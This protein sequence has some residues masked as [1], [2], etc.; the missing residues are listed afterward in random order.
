[1]KNKNILSFKQHFQQVMQP[2]DPLL[3]SDMG[4]KGRSAYFESGLRHAQMLC[5][6]AERF[7]RFAQV[8]PEKYSVNFD[9]PQEWSKEYLLQA[10][11]MS[12][13]YLFASAL[14]KH[15]DLVLQSK[16]GLTEDARKTLERF[17]KNPK[18]REAL[19]SEYNEKYNTLPSLI[20]RDDFVANQ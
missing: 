15:S 13:S 14:I 3:L 5:A 1:M 12:G 11:L 2:S 19:I 8:N 6:K 20:D 4:H 7:L 10:G 18:M 17:A 9:M 16:A